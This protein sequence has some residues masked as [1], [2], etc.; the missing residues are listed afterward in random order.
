MSKINVD[1]KIVG[2]EDVYPNPWNPNI[3]SVR[4]EEATTESIGMFGMLDPLTVRPHPDQEGKYQI[5]DGAHRQASCMKLGYKVIP[6]NVVKGLTEGEAK[7]LTVIANETRGY[8]EKP[9]LADL[10]STIKPEFGEELIQ[11]LP[12]YQNELDD[13]LAMSDHDWE[14]FDSSFDGSDDQSDSLDQFNITHPQEG[15]DSFESALCL[16][17]E[18]YP[19]A[20]LKRN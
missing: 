2:I 18:K 15:A 4:V 11:G 8:A 3:Q 20:E 16:F 13:L 14:D 5:I 17:L 1:I 6:V 10:L 19:S 12:Y 7:K 9:A